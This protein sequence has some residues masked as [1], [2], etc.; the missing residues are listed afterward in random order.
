MK[1]PFFDRYRT[2]LR[3]G[4][5]RSLRGDDIARRL[6]RYHVGL[7]NAEGKPADAMGP[8][9]H[10]VFVLFVAE[11]LGAKVESALPAALAIELVHQFALIHHDIENEVVERRGRPAAWK[12]AGKAKGINAGDLL[13]ALALGEA[14][15][16][17][18][19]AVTCLLDGLRDSV[20]G[21]SL[22]LDF[23]SRWVTAPEYR[24]MIQLK[25]G[26]LLRCAFELGGIVANA[27]PD[28]TRRLASFGEELG[29]ALHI[30]DDLLGVWGAVSQPERPAAPDL[31]RRKKSVPVVAAYEQGTD[32][33]RQALERI[34]R[35]TSAS[36]SDVA[37]VLAMF[38]RLGIRAD[39]EDRV[40][41]HLQEAVKQLP[42]IPFSEDGLRELEGLFAEWTAFIEP[43]EP[44]GE[45]RGRTAG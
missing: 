3:V 25:T 7:E 14:V 1:P 43:G 22:D 8:Q 30:R 17:C 39:N 36:D 32:A 4:L 19:E 26:A 27:P 35:G 41:S 42:Y 45:P 44:E 24:A 28:T 18:P 31:R 23:A 37:K 33:D 11:E 20:D 12:L 2:I 21:Q 16:A 5:A 40:R 10:P 13:A 38:D 6:L 9:M 34:M 15:N 29:M